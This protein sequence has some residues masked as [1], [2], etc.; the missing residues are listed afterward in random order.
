MSFTILV[1]ILIS[2]KYTI[3]NKIFGTMMN[4]HNSGNCS[5]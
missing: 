5:L 3:F 2:A 4:M 1:I